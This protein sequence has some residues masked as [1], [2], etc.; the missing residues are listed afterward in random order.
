[1][2]LREASW[3][4]TEAAAVSCR[5]CRRRWF[6]SLLQLP[7]KKNAGPIDQLS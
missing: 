5:E 2:R 7:R 1:M 6:G 4:S 3:G